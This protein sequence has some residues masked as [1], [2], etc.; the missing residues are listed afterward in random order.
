MP[1]YFIQWDDRPGRNAD[2]IAQ[3]GL[4]KDDV[5]DVLFDPVLKQRSRTTGHPMWSGFTGSGRWVSVVF[6][7]IDAVTMLPITAFPPEEE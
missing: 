1:Y 2:K 6:M 7:W 3:H 5:E 4:T